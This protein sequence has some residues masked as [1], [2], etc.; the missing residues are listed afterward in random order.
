MRA[1]GLEEELRYDSPVQMTTRVVVEPAVV[2]GKH[3]RAGQMVVAILGAANR[4]PARFPDPDRLDVQR[5]GPSH[6]AFGAGLNC[7][8]G[9][10][11][12]RLEVQIAFSALLRRFSRLELRT[13]PQRRQTLAIRG[14]R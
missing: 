11:L 3:L 6:L 9:A 12:A 8:L 4:D 2:G 10:P 7:C 14:L 5:H 1:A 13:E